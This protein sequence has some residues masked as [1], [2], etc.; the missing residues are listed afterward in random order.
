MTGIPFR[1]LADNATA[2]VVCPGTGDAGG[3]CD[4]GLPKVSAS[5]T[6]VHDILTIFFGV[7]AIISIL[8][9]VIGGML[10][11]TSGGNPQN[12]KKAR[13]TITYAVVGLIVSLL[14]EVI[15]AFALNKI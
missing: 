7:A 2:Q 15:V 4:T 1:L 13:D 11:V 12:A 8:M 9:I 10:L 6:E 3:S 5:S 14:A